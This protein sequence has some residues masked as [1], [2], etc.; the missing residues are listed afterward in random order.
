MGPKGYRG[1]GPTRLSLPEATR[2]LPPPAHRSLDTHQPKTSRP[3]HSASSTVTCIYRSLLS[4]SHRSQHTRPPP[5]LAQAAIPLPHNKQTRNPTSLGFWPHTRTRSVHRSRTTL[6]LDL[7]IITL[8]PLSHISAYIA[9]SCLFCFCT[10]NFLGFFFLLH[11]VQYIHTLA[12]SSIWV[13][14]VV[15]IRGGLGR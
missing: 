11:T 1:R 8:S 10:I 13:E 7:Y 5:S 14:Y 4:T 9:R 6:D 12:V 3:P 2:R 15:R